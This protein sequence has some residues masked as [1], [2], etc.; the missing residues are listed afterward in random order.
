MIVTYD[1]NNDDWELTEEE[2]KVLK[3]PRPAKANYTADSPELTEERAMRLGDAMSKRR[4][5]REDGHLRFDMTKE[6][7]AFIEKYIP[8]STFKDKITKIGHAFSDREMAA[9]IWNSRQDLPGKHEDLRRIAEKTYDEVL[10]K[11]IEERIAYDQD[12][13]ELFRNNDGGFVYA[14]DIHEEYFD[15]NGKFE[16]T[17]KYIQGYY[18]TCEIAY[19]NGCRKGCFFDILKYQIIY[20]DTVIIRSRNISSP[21]FEPDEDKQVEESNIEG[22]S[23]GRIEYDKKGQIIAC[24]SDELPKERLIRVNPLDNRRFENAFVIYPNPFKENDHVKIVESEII[25][26]RGVSGWVETSS[27]EWRQLVIRSCSEDSIEDYSDATL[28]V[29]YWDEDRRVWNYGHIAPSCLE[30]IDEE[31]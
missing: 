5:I 10:K 12:A 26:E 1:S 15:E 9:I 25:C 22:N 4:S 3:A 6:Y 17:E 23:I 14:L 16:R 21:W 27:E 2:K 13:L 20:E 28:V 8:S 30:L 31:S 24:E 11:Q 18:G 19:R 7:A 29:R